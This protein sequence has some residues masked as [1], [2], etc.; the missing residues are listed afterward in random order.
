MHLF[1]HFYNHSK[2]PK[3]FFFKCSIKASY[4]NKNPTCF[5]PYSRTIFRGR[6]SLLVPTTRQLH[7]LSFIC[8]GMW[9][10]SL[11]LY[12]YP[13]YLPVCCLVVNDQTAHRQIHWIHI[14][15]QGI[16]HIPIQTNDEACS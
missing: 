6:P 2:T 7:F 5:G 1:Q 16:D 14:Q 9:S 3:E 13:V 8:I 15:I 12:V 10:Y 4:I 11:Y